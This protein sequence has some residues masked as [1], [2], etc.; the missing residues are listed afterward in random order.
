MAVAD[1]NVLDPVTESGVNPGNTAFTG[2]PSAAGN[3]LTN[4]TDVDI[5]GE[6]K[7]VS[8]VNGQLANVGV[9]V[10]GTYGSVTI[11]ADGSYTYTLDNNDPQTQALAQGETATDQFTYT[12]VDAN[13]ATSSTTLTI[14]ITGTNDAPDLRA[15]TT[16]TI[17]SV[18]TETNAALTAS[19]T[20][21]V[22]DPDTIDTIASS[23]TSVTLGGT[24]G[25]LTSAAVLGMLSVSPPVGL[26]ANSGDTHNLGWTF[27]SGSQAFDYL[28]TGQS[29]TLTYTVTSS[30][31]HGGTDTQNV[32]VTINGSNDAAVISGTSSGAV[33]EASGTNNSIPGTPTAL[34]T[35]T[36]TDVDNTPNSFTAVA[37]GA[38][39]AN[40]Y[41]T[42]AM[43]VG[44]VWTYTLNNANAAVNALNV[45]GSLSDSFVVTTVDGTQKTVN[46][47]ITGANDAAVI[48]GTSTGTVTEAGGTST[49]GTPIATGTL[50]NTDVDNTPN[51]FTAVAAG[52]AT[53]NGYGTFAMA[54]GGVWTYTLNNAN[55]AVNALSTGQTLSDSFAVTTV[56]GTQQTVNV[57]I[58]GTSDNNPPIVAND[59]IWVSNSTIV[60][61]PAAALLANDIDVDGI[62]LSLTNIVVTTGTLA[63]P[64]IINPDGSFTFTTAAAGGTVAAPTVV[65]LTYT[66]SDGAGGASTGTVTVNVLSTTGGVDTINL[67]GVA[68]YQASYISG[69]SGADVITDGAAISTLLGG[70]G[71]DILTGNAGN[72]LLIGGD[73][74]DTL[75]GGAGNDILRGGIGNSDTMDGG[76]GTEDLLDF[77]DGTLAVTFTLAQTAASTS[78]ANGTGGLGNNDSYQNLEGVIGTNLNDNITGSSGNDILRGGG[79]NDTLNG[80]T[81]NDLIDFTDGTSGINFTL[82]Q[83]AGGVINLVAA[84]LGTD[85]YSNFEGVIGTAFADTLTGSANND[86][87]RGGTGNDTISGLGGNDRIIGGDGADTLTG[88]LGNDTFAFGSALNSFDTITDFNATGADKIELDDLIFAALGSGVTRALDATNFASNAGG[89]ALDGDD[90]ILFDSAT[91]KL[92]Y[93]ADGSAAGAKVLFAQLDLSGLVGGT[94]GVDVTDFF[95]I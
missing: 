36:D 84:G 22:T 73:N 47:T 77:S 71:L 63:T 24:T 38:A 59:T 34:G 81:G 70:D 91:G 5:L 85:T 21:T 17:S 28:G 46:V 41:G 56:D 54:A 62:S 37:A 69:G 53:A 90:Y 89:N 94:A 78:I 20:L 58:N 74:N 80:A 75:T 66:T 35:L 13:G 42:F 45:G 30:D 68:A 93:D 26:A 12:V 72:D 11:A 3:V 14:T 15:V 65:T 61:L 55:A 19:G 88:G 7:T 50:T 87:L 49:P 79:G 60:T 16:D 40:G 2:D 43:T 51:S 39:T 44:G 25:S 64:V 1:T 29:L 48:S 31:G 67:T 4:D 6:T 27:N 8:A 18:Q 76:A 83:G 33:T 32:T 10:T 82:V 52:A 9:A 23:V 57:T 86:E 95:I 92:F